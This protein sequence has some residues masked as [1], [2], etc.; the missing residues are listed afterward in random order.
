MMLTNNLEQA[1]LLRNDC[2]VIS[3]LFLIVVFFGFFMVMISD[4]PIGGMALIVSFG[5]GFVLSFIDGMAAEE[6]IA[7]YKEIGQRKL[8]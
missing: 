3:I 8:E 1:I 2:L 5:F 4:S 6:E 7:I